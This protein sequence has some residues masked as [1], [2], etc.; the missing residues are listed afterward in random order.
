MVRLRQAG[1]VWF[2]F[3]G[4][5]HIFFLMGRIESLFE[6]D[7]VSVGDLRLLRVFF[8]KQRALGNSVKRLEKYAFMF[9]ALFGLM[10]GLELGSAGEDDLLE[11]SRRIRESGY[12]DWTKHDLHVAV[13]RFYKVIEGRNLSYPAKLDFFKPPPCPGPSKG[14]GDVISRV[15]CGKLLGVCRNSRDKCIVS[16][17]YEGGFRIGEL[18]A[19][20]R[21]DVRL[22]S[23]GVEVHV[24]DKVGCKSGSRD[25]FLIESYG[26]IREY[27]ETHLGGLKSPFFVDMRFNRPVRMKQQGVRTMLRK[28]ARKAGLDPSRFYPH[29][30]RHTAATEKAALGFSESQ[31][32]AYMGWKP[33]SDMASVY[34]HLTGRE[35]RQAYRKALGLGEREDKKLKVCPRCGYENNWRARECGR[36]FAVLD[37]R[38]AVE[39]RELMDWLKKY[40]KQHEK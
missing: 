9:K 10:P 33:G 13:K 14:P 37:P 20:D 31:L 32:N 6:L 5:F 8:D 35:L 15:E 11:L 3:N 40:R 7:G 4:V 12:S 24:P 16:M 26:R 36:C 39:D 19:L 21:G 23:D 28:K 30:F 34:I 22:V 38:K 17:L 29:A 2:Y 18:L 25:I 27:L 1:C